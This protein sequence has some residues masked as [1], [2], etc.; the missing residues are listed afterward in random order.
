MTNL[1][2]C[3]FLFQLRITSFWQSNQS[4][5]PLALN[6]SYTPR[7]H[8][9][10]RSSYKLFRQLFKVQQEKAYLLFYIDSSSFQ[11]R[12]LFLYLSSITFS[13]VFF[14]EPTPTTSTCL[15]TNPM[16]ARFSPWRT[17]PTR[18]AFRAS[19]WRMPATPDIRRAVAA[20]RRS[21]PSSSST[22]W[23]TKHRTRET[24]RRIDSSCQKVRTGWH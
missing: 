17:S 14:L 8:P 10:V 5:I 7:H 20:R 15:S 6:G 11:F 22:S 12:K 18:C 3:P 1:F 19:R 23:S 13:S 4:S 2:S 9:R 16:P 24:L 21:C